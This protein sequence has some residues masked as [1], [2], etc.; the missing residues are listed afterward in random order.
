ME[1]RKITQ[2]EAATVKDVMNAL[3]CNY[4]VHGEIGLRELNDFSQVDF[5]SLMPKMVNILS[6]Y[7]CKLGDVEL[8]EEVSEFLKALS[9][10]CKIVVFLIENKEAL[11]QVDALL[12]EVYIVYNGFDEMKKV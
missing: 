8:V 4:L 7:S 10:I 11:D 5:F 12:T 1:H 6:D 3:G 9:K 2:S